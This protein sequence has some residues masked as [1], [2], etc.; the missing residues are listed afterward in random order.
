M[1]FLRIALINSF[2]LPAAVAVG[3]EDVIVVGRYD[4]AG[5]ALILPLGPHDH[6]AGVSETILPNQ[7][8]KP[9]DPAFEKL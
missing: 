8:L 3:V 7:R 9:G 4:L 6:F 5:V 1:G 2:I